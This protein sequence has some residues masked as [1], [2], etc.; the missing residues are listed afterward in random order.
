MI[1]SSFTSNVKEIL[2][3][4]S[5]NLII[6]IT[7]VKKANDRQKQPVL[8]N[9]HKLQ[10]NGSTANIKFIMKDQHDWKGTHSNIDMFVKKRHL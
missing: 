8:V 5:E 6:N 9:Y 10:G 7:Q 2:S 1:S 3:R 4:L